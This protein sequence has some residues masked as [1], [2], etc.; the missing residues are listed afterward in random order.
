[1][2]MLN[3]QKTIKHD[4]LKESNCSSFVILLFLLFFLNIFLNFFRKILIFFKFLSCNL[5]YLML[6]GETKNEKS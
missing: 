3:N 6:N 5:W 1:M 4:I 2:Q